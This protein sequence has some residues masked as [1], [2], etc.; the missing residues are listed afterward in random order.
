MELKDVPPKIAHT[1]LRS[2]CRTVGPQAEKVTPGGNKTS[3][4][5]DQ[6]SPICL[7]HALLS[8]RDATEN[9]AIPA[10]PTSWRNRKATKIP[11][12]K[13]PSV[14]KDSNRA[15]LFDSFKFINPVSS[16]SQRTDSV[17]KWSRRSSRSCAQKA[18][19]SKGKRI[20]LHAQ[21]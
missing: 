9:V 16:L 4:I 21:S 13:P 5:A 19:R 1:G 7:L 20:N 6:W 18:T 2:K 10:R 15:V 11:V 14:E 3:Q 12:K 8:S 17:R